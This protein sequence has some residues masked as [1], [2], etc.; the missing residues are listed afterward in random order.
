MWEQL[1]PQMLHTLL[2]CHKTVSVT[3]KLRTKERTPQGSIYD[4]ARFSPEAWHDGGGTF[5]LRLGPSN[6]FKVTSYYEWRKTHF[7]WW[8]ISFCYDSARWK[9]KQHKMTRCS[10][11]KVEVILVLSYL[12][13]NQKSWGYCKTTIKEGQW[14]AAKSGESS[15]HKR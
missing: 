14:G 7:S 6:S 8:I 2:W 10:M 9:G 11:V 1:K 13:Y 15:K 3:Q 12:K 4:R 5:F